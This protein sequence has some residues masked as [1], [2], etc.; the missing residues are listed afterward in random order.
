MGAS[1][2]VCWRLWLAGTA[3]APLMRRC[4]LL[5]ASVHQSNVF[6]T[7]DCLGIYKSPSF[8]ALPGVCQLPWL[9]D[10]LQ[11][12][13][14]RWREQSRS[15]RLRELQACGAQVALHANKSESSCIL[16]NKNS[17]SDSATVLRPHLCSASRLQFTA[18]RRETTPTFATSSLC[19]Q[20][21]CPSTPRFWT[22]AKHWSAVFTRSALRRRTRDQTSIS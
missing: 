20:R 12:H 17:T 9:P 18:W 7:W 4:P 11:S 2:A 8:C 21:F 14:F 16:F 1:S 13:T 15:A 19:L 5:N 10:R 6:L 3:I 22:W